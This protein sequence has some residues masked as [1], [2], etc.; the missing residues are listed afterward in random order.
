MNVSTFTKWDKYRLIALCTF[1]AVVL[2]STRKLPLILIATVPAVAV[3][4]LVMRTRILRHFARSPI[5]QVAYVSLTEPVY[6]YYSANVGE[7]ED[8]RPMM[9]RRREKVGEKR[10][11]TPLKR[12][13]DPCYV[14]FQEYIS[15]KGNPLVMVCGRSGMG[16]SELMKVL[17]LAVVKSQK[18]VFS[19]KPN[20]THL[21]LPYPVVDVS[22]HVPNPFQDADA[23]STA[24]AL[25][26]PANLRGIMLSQARAIVK[27]I[28]GESKDWNQFRANLKRM[29]RKGTD[30]QLE[31]LALI[32]QQIGGL[33]VGE[34]SFN[35]DLAKDVVLDFSRL[36]EAAKTFY[37]EIALRQIWDSLTGRAGP[38]IS[39][40]K[41]TG[42]TDQKPTTAAQSIAIVIDEVHRLTQLY[43]VDARTILDTMMLEVRQF[44]TL[45]TATQ[46]QTDIPD[47]LRQF[48]T[49]LAFH[50]T[51]PKELEALGKIDPAYPWIVR[52]LQPY[53][54]VDLS[55][56]VGEAGL[57]P[58][59]RVDMSA[60]PKIDVQ[61][62]ESVDIAQE[63]QPQTP[64]DYRA[65]VEEE[66]DGG[67]VVWVSRLASLVEQRYHVA[68][69]AAKLRLR[70]VLLKLL[71]AGVVQVQRFDDVG[72]GETVSLYFA[73]STNE[74][75]GPLHKWMLGQAVEGC[76]GV[77]HV[78]SSGE[79]LPDIET[80]R[81]YIEVETG[82]KRRVDDLQER[83]T[84][85][86]AKP[87]VVLVPDEAVAEEYRRKLVNDDRATV[88]TLREF[89]LDS[90][91]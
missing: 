17:L 38:A 55:F 89:L 71:K 84:K 54:F 70:D 35:I 11:D 83:I 57:V 5:R 91:A 25:A 34:G 15:S 33:A 23:F 86:T 26:F 29:E 40:M 14:N 76:K 53:E 59:F 9:E 10:R 62:L 80:G 13:I 47:N 36:D 48:G 43:Q 30:I 69:D 87:F 56:R 75:E 45:L 18:I 88:E 77:V 79:A 66:L 64:V 85:F 24:Y 72:S 60:V 44:G 21:R 39:G 32:E 63:P 49:E 50:T 2:A 31:A 51:I 42:S 41:L 78:A 4:L 68:K 28:A 74:N 12:R 90:R 27:N 22:R 73:K 37:A 58:V 65:V 8:G 81:A 67:R 46:N 1:F 82:L 6:H 20:D 7:D 61:R 16:K 19:F 52:H 3:A